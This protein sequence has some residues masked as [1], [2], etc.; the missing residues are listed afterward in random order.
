MSSQVLTIS[1]YLKKNQLTLSYNHNLI[2]KKI[3]DFDPNLFLVQNEIEFFFKFKSKYLDQSG[4]SNPLLKNQCLMKLNL[5][6]NIILIVNLYFK[7]KITIS[8]NT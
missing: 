3:L 6:I 7:S 2:L 5:F 8:S 1:S 4:N